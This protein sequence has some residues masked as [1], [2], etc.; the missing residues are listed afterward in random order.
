MKTYLL[1]AGDR[2]YPESG[3]G[4]WIGCFDTY[5]EADNLVIKTPVP[6]QVFESGKRKGLIKPNQGY[7]PPVCY[8]NDRKYDWYQIVDLMEWMTK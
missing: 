8:I 6:P 3:D 5:Q 4:N 2:Y 7:I 1:I